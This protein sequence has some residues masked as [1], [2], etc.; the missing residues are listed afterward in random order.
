MK[1]AVSCSAP[2]SGVGDQGVIGRRVIAAWALLLASAAGGC[3][4]VPLAGDDSVRRLLSLRD[5]G[6]AP[7]RRG[8]PV[9]PALLIQPGA[10][11]AF[12]DTVSIA[13]SERAGEFAFYQLATW[14]DRPIRQVPLLLQRRIESAGL[15][16]ACGQLGD[17]LAADWLVM[18]RIDALHHD[19]AAARGHVTLT[20]E[21][22][23]RPL[24]R[25]LASHRFEATAPAQRAGAAAASEAL[26]VALGH[27]L[28]DLLRWLEP[29]LRAAVQGAGP[30]RT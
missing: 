7:P 8:S 3:V 18:I 16:G 11:H 1:H 15:A 6:P 14:T 2:L 10:G 20:A 27:A 24:R 17:P 25:R 19:V 21:L 4:N 22:Y 26:S 9:V 5:A 30:A 29:A 12:G 28:D 13:Y 23:E